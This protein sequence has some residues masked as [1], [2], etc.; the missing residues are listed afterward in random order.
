MSVSVFFDYHNPVCDG[1][2]AMLGAEKDDDAARAAMAREGWARIREKDLC[3]LCQ[4]RLRE[5]GQMPERKPRRGSGKQ[6][7]Q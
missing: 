6:I 4:F 5:T 2:G 1:C 3:R 7:N